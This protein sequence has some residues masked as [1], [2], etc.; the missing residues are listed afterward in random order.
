MNRVAIVVLNWNGINDT[1]KC[2][3]S[4]L[5]QTYTNKY[6]LIVDNG[7]TDNSKILL[8]KYRKKHQDLVDVI[9]NPVNYGF[10]GGVNA[11]IKRALNAGFEYVALFNND[12]VADKNWLKHLVKSVTSDEKSGVATGLLLHKH[13]KTIDS[14]GDWYSVWGMP[15]PRNRGDITQKAHNGGWVFSATGGASLYRAKMLQDIGLF[16]ENFFAYYED[17]D[18]SFR[19]QLAG[20]RVAYEP[21]AIAY[22]KQGATSKKIPGFT[23]YQTFKNLPLLF[24]KNAPLKL[25]FPIG[26]RLLVL[27][28][29]MFANAIIKGKGW[30]ALKGWVASIWYFWIS[31]LWQRFKI[32]SNK[33]VTTTYIKSM[34]WHDLPPDQTG[35]RKLRKLF[36]GKD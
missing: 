21:K 35:M 31:S 28:W 7:S 29:M 36:T 30:Y 24:I 12:A 6:V 3:D 1:L 10:A 15:F 18:I 16:D 27:Y 11:G 4:L 13:G 20:W 2:L 26:I 22:H 5:D 14:T 8:D 9:Y 19:A 17:V 32:Q 25:L 34:I 23:V 33:K